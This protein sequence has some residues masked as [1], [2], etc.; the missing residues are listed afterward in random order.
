MVC[1]K[2]IFYIRYS[3]V[4]D[5]KQECMICK[6]NFYVSVI[7]TTPS[8]PKDTHMKTTTK[9]LIA[10]LSL[11]SALAGNVMAQT[12]WTGNVNANVNNAGNWDNGLPTSVGNPG[13][14]GSGA[15]ALAA[16]FNYIGYYVTQNGGSIAGNSWSLTNGQWTLNAGGEITGGVNVQGNT[17]GSQLLTVN[18]G[19]INATTLTV[20]QTAG[21]ARSATLDMLAGDFDLSGQLAMNSGSTVNIS[22][23]TVDIG[24]N[25][26][27]NGGELNISGGTVTIT[28]MLGRGGVT[29]LSGGTTTSATFEFLAGTQLI[30]GAGTAGS[31][32]VDSFAGAAGNRDIDWISGS[33]MAMTVTGDSTWASTEWAA[34][35]MFY[36]G[37]D[38]NT[39][40][41][42]A[43]VTAAN[44]L[45]TGVNFDFD[46]TTNTLSVIPEPSTFALMGLAGLAAL[47]LRRR[48]G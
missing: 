45:G 38:F 3:G 33:Q 16:A 43:T 12:T 14:I 25:I 48:R 42:W 46:S 28:S 18:G 8:L 27:I 20:V 22:G 34:G 1:R 31:Y 36:N 15:G 29:T 47:F 9:T 40:G 37:N 2:Y 17:D 44:G 41:D 13:T 39:L 26:R 5:G 24:T 6:V 10:G 19:T 35:R 23:G 32:T 11:I 21:A 30:L 4:T 7:S